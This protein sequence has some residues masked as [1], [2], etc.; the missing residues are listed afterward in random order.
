V[1]QRAARALPRSPTGRYRRAVTPA[2]F[3]ADASLLFLARRLRFLGYDV[4]DVPRARLDE[5]FEAAARD[6]RTV[7]TMSA[8]HPKRWARV[9]VLR[10]ARNADAESVRR[11]AD[12]HPP[13]G[14]PF[15]RCPD[16]NQA[17]QRRHAFEAR[18]EV[19]PRVLR[20]ATALHYCPV[21][22]RWYW[23]GSHVARIR[24][25]LETA[26]GRPLPAGGTDTP[27]PGPGDAG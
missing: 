9:P 18:G 16:C 12:A 20:G 1:A 21:C 26:L 2:R 24:A 25:W 22:G 4:A 8:R 13:A 17:L 15:S 5:L 23:N 3:T 10:V 27:G 11:I 7:I 14:P 6:G 19:P